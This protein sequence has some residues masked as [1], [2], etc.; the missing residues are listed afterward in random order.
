MTVEDA[1][2]KGLEALNRHDAAGYAATYAAGAVVHD[3]Q[4]GEPLKGRDKVRADIQ[5]FF[6]AFPD[7]K[8][9]LRSLLVNED[10]YAAEFEMTGTHLGPIPTPD[11][12]EIPASNKPVRFGGV[13]IGRVDRNGEIAEE[14][15][16]YDLASLLAQVS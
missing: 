9:S 6:R 3:P 1:V 11:G 5:D 10:T 13:S 14:R 12:V 2:H 15:R 8:G 7:L 4:Y 16:Y